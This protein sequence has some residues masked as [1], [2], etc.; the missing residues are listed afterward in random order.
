M[1]FFYSYNIFYFFACGLVTWFFL[2][3]LVPILSQRYLDQPNARSSHLLPTPRGGGVAFVLVGSIA[4]ALLGSWLPLFCLPLA[5]VGF[6]D[7]R[8]NLPAGLRYGIQL[9]TAL[10]LL[11]ISPLSAL[12]ASWLIWLL[13][14][15]AATAVI[16]FINF[17]DG[18]DG[19]VAG[20][21]VVL[22]AVAA[23]TG[24]PAFWPLVGA[25]LGFL[26]WNWSPAKV[27][28]GDV[29]ST[30]LGAV[31]AG[32]VLQ[33]ASFSA[34]VGLLLVATPLLADACI[35]V[36]RRLR[37]GQR[38]FQ[39][40]RLHLFQR[41]HQAGWSHVRVACSYIAATGVLAIALLVGGWLWVLGLAGVVLIIGLWLDQRVALAF[42]VASRS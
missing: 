21:M 15:I 36:L 25:L 29:G 19:L 28:M 2:W 20:C 39:A 13:L 18:L 12:T 17:T 9:A 31:F 22:F 8:H 7:D 6:L 32:V 5:L 26:F 1:F 24:M 16:N 30:F 40:H 10:L 41:L 37:A 4:V 14:L 38:I 42:V 35:C 11:L 3:C 23:L 27:F 33:Q 34:A